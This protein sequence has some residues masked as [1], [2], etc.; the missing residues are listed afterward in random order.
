MTLLDFS[1]F[2]DPVTR[3]KTMGFISDLEYDVCAFGKAVKTFEGL[4]VTPGKIKNDLSSYDY[5]Y[6]P[7][8]NG[9]AAL[10][11]SSEFLAWIKTISRENTAVAVCGGTL[12]LGAAG[13]L[14]GKKATTHPNLI[15]YLKKFTEDIPDSRVVND[16]NVIT[17]GGVT[18][19]IDLGLY[20]CEKIAGRE[21][22]EKIQTQMD[23]HAYP[24]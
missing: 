5:V 23:Y 16:G 21:V 4:E 19:A 24:Y 10:L 3:L 14:K 8:G 6:I 12:L 1:G 17:A 7:G 2:Y 11:S 9:I 22:R 15:S 13:Y 20:I 18:S